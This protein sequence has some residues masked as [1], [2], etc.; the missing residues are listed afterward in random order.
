MYWGVE[1]PLASND[2]DRMTHNHN[3]RRQSPTTPTF[4]LLTS[5]AILPTPTPCT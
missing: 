1:E 3:L 4:E 2:D 5:L